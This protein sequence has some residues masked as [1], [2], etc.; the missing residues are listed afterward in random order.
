VARVPVR[1]GTHKVICEW[2]PP[3]GLEGESTTLVLRGNS[4]VD[5]WQNG[6]RERSA[7]FNHSN[8]VALGL[9]PEGLSVAHAVSD[10]CRM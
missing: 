2:P 10:L 4:G 8:R 3:V 1:T 6:T 9:H 7:F 5:T